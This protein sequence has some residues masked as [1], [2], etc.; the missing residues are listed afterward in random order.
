MMHALKNKEYD[1]H[2]NR[3]RIDPDV[4]HQKNLQDFVTSNTLRFQVLKI[5]KLPSNFLETDMINCNEEK[6][7]QHT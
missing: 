6:V 5:M 7:Q 3:A 2:L 4:I 1:K